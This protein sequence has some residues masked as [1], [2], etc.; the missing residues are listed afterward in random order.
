YFD[1]R[2]LDT[3]CQEDIDRLARVLSEHKIDV[4]LHGPYMDLSPGGVD[5]RVK[6]VTLERIGKT[7]ELASL[8]RPKTVVFHPGFDRWRFEGYRDLWLRNSIESW[9]PI[10]EKAEQ[11]GTTIAVE[12][13]FEEGPQTLRNLI[14]GVNSPNF[15]FCFDAGHY[16]V[17]S[18]VP[19]TL[20]FDVVGEFLAEVHLHDNHGTRD[21]HLPLGEGEIDFGEFFDLLGPISP[22]PILAIEPH[23]EAHL[24]SSLRAL[25]KYLS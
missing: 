2:A 1:G 6:E 21:D 22:R 12:N 19:L 15:R 8:F 11:M 10:A 9:K 7:M 13:V 3:A 17:F 25:E 18:E 16:F 24:W 23:E 4:T 14:E 5:A 20:W